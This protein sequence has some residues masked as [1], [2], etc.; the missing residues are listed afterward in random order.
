MAVLIVCDQVGC[1]MLTLQ[2]LSMQRILP[3]NGEYVV[4]VF[5]TRICQYDPFSSTSETAVYQG[6]ARRASSQLQGLC[7]S[8]WVRFAAD[9]RSCHGGA[10][11]D[12]H[13]PQLNPHRNQRGSP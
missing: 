6:G 5:E 3:R 11:N 10:R 9:L 1:S 4:W 12:P 7:S 13:E 2:H 8:G